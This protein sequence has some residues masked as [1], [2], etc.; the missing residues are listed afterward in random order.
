MRIQGSTR[1]ISPSLPQR[2]HHR[3]LRRQDLR[4]RRLVWS[5]EENDQQ[6]AGLPREFTFVFLVE[7]PPPHI[8]DSTKFIANENVVIGDISS[9]F[10]D[11]TIGIKIKPNI[12]GFGLDIGEDEVQYTT[13]KGEVGQRFRT[14]EE[15]QKPS[16]AA[17]AVA[18]MKYG[19]EKA[20]RKG[21]SYVKKS[22]SSSPPPTARDGLPTLTSTATATTNNKPTNPTTTAISPAKSTITTFPSPEAS[23]E[24]GF[25]IGAGGVDA[26]D[27]S[28]TDTLSHYFK[29]TR[30]ASVFAPANSHVNLNAN[31]TPV[32]APAPK[33]RG[34]V[35]LQRR[36]TGREEGERRKLF[37]FAVMEGSFED[38]IELPGN[39]VT[40]VEPTIGV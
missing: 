33:G 21:S 40:S 18:T 7:Q 11:L 20:V 5:L 12:T 10:K 35:E 25:V 1:S 39:A 3:P 13:I 15:H 37:N 17:G 16:N 26:F 27:G 36:E 23:T 4:D 28:A 19:A 30:S 38:L 32:A 14:A 24:A 2:S 31:S 34:G 6:E 8:V 9:I 22:L 29:S